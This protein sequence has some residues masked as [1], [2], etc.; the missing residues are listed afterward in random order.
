MTLKKKLDQFSGPTSELR[1][2]FGFKV[3]PMNQ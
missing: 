2:I 1:P 3:E